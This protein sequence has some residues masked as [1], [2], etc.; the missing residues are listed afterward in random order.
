[1]QHR[2]LANLCRVEI[3]G[4]RVLLVQPLTFM[5]LSGRAVKPLLCRWRLAPEQL[6]VIHD[7]LDLPPGSIRLRPGGGSGGHKGIQSIIDHLNS[8]GFSRLRIGIGRPREGA[9]VDYVLQPFSREE[10]QAL[11]NVWDYACEAARCWVSDGIDAAMN[12]FNKRA[13]EDR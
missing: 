1:M 13:P 4:M 12:R 8:A 7:D 10:R 3:G 6:L 9:V 5:N 2:H 11:E